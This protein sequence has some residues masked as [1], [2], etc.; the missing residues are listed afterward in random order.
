MT[1]DKVSSEARPLPVGPGSPAPEGDVQQPPANL[2]S[3]E[4]APTVQA[5]DLFAHLKRKDE[6]IIEL[7]QALAARERQIAELE[8]ALAEARR[9]S[10]DPKLTSSMM[11]PEYAQMLADRVGVLADA[12][13]WLRADLLTAVAP[14]NSVERKLAALFAMPTTGETALT[15]PPQGEV[16]PHWNLSFE[17]TASVILKVRAKPNYVAGPDSCPNSIEIALSGTT[18][19]LVL[20][21]PIAWSEIDGAEPFQLSMNAEPNRAITVYAGLRLFEREGGFTQHFFGS[22]TLDPQ[23]R[24]MAISGQLK[25]PDLA[26]VDTERSPLLLL[27]FTPPEDGLQLRL[28]YINVRFA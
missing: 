7:R 23:R 26:A 17:E 13:A 9:H 2:K 5:E 25:L 12:L 6:L 4:D 20:E 18:R 15:V 8:H 11:P 10:R 21:T 3:P 16:G 19:W 14:A 1:Q 24:T 27:F 22:L 28:D